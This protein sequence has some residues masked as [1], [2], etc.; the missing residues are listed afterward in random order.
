MAAP[1][2]TGSTN[3]QSSV[4]AIISRTLIEALRQGTPYLLP[5]AVTPSVYVKGGGTPESK[6]T[7]R[8]FSVSDLAVGTP[9]PIVEGTP[10]AAE[11]LDLR[12]MDFA[13]A[14]YA[15]IVH[16]T[17]LAI[18]E[19]PFNIPATMT[20]VIAEWGRQT[21]DALAGAAWNA[22][23][24]G[25]T[26]VLAAGEGPAQNTNPPSILDFQRAAA[27]LAKRGVDSIGG[28]YFALVDST[29]AFALRTEK[30]ELSLT[31]VQKYA[32]E[33]GLIDGEIGRVQ[34]IRF[35]ETKGKA[36][37]SSTVHRSV[38]TGANALA[39][40]ELSQI[41]SAYVAPEPSAADPLG[42]NAYASV[43]FMFGAKVIDIGAPTAA[44]S[45]RYAIVESTPV[46]L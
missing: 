5:G 32:D 24:A 23:P 44:D 30:G 31:E 6:Y 34:G 18:L 15:K 2:A 39:Y 46:A 19:S 20:D 37:M 9:T 8:Y 26:V 38:V 36:L 11:G 21:M 45:Y 10:P 13:A 29:V 25:E 41:A 35:I 43:K 12:F 14:Q 40:S 1:F 4:Q 27:I 16:S 22:K 3:F 42:L 17:D 33:A 7:F 28:N